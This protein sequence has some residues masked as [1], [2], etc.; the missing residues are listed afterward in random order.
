MRISLVRKFAISKFSSAKE[1]CYNIGSVICSSLYPGPNTSELTL[2]IERV[3]FIRQYTRIFYT[4]R[5][6]GISVATQVS[7]LMRMSIQESANIKFVDTKLKIFD[8]QSYRRNTFRFQIVSFLEERLFRKY[9]YPR[10]ILHSCLC[11]KSCTLVQQHSRAHQ[12][13]FSI[14]CIMNQYN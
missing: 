1:S 9:F 6:Q 3:V 12:T 10:V 2:L 14:T 4:S 11:D 5:V 7:Y 13:F 8:N